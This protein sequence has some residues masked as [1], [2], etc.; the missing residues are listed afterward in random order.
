MALTTIINSHNATLSGADEVRL[1]HQLQVLD[2]RLIHHAS[3]VAEIGLTQL[4][5]PKRVEID[6][7]L[8]LGPLGA[9]LVSHQTAASVHRAARLAINDVERQLEREHAKQRGEPTFG[10]PS[11]RRPAWQQ[12]ERSREA[13]SSG[14]AISKE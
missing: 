12:S 14:E 4:E 2:R 13:I 8:R 9:H 5:G 7:R 3:P 6:F 1:R 10:V 11:R